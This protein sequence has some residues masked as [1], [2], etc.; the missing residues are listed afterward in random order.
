MRTPALPMQ[1]LATMVAATVAALSAAQARGQAP[2]SRTGPAGYPVKP[3]RLVVANAA[4]GT[5]DIVARVIAPHVANDI[6]QQIVVDN[7]PGAAG[8][9]ARDIVAR[10]PGDGYTLLM[11]NQ[12]IVFAAALQPNATSDIARDFAAVASL[13]VSPNV[14]VTHPALPARS[15]TELVA[16]LNTRAVS[17][18]SGGIGS[19]THVA[20]ELFLRS[21]GAMALN[22]PYKSAGPALTDVVAGHVQFM[23]ATMPSALPYLRAG[24]LRALAV[25]GAQRS[26]AAPQLPTVAE[27]GVRGYSYDTWYGIFAP[28][29]AGSAL[30]NWLNAAINRALAD[31]AVH[32]RLVESGLDPAASS[33]AAF[34]KLFRDDVTR[35]TRAIREAGIKAE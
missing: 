28:A 18:G 32:E 23:I 31:P 16:L 17:F 21:A 27:A 8:L 5:P 11:T 9:I 19:S 24:K 33:P 30:V 14:L 15:V 7:R 6:G 22:V 26:P 1:V 4:G 25:T 10:S 3:V 29:A 35:W 12:T 34:Q 2:G 20:M 13:G